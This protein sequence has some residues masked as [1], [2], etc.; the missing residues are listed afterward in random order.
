MILLFPD[1]DTLRLA[2]TS[3]LV[4][5][6]VTLAPAAVTADEQ[7]RVYVE[8]SVS[9]P[10][11]LGKTLDRLGVKGSKRH[12]LGTPRDVTSWLELL[13]LTKAAGTPAIAAQQPVLFEL[14]D[15]DDLP[16]L[17]SEMLRLG[18]D[19]QGFRW[20][21]RP[22]D[23]DRHRVLLRVIGPP[24]YTLLRALDRPAAGG[25]RAYLEAAPRVWVELGHQHPLA[26]QVK[27]AEGQTA[28]IRPPA[29]WLFLDDAP[30]RDVYELLKFDLPAG[31][32][33]WE[34]G[35][36]AD[37]IEVPLKL[38]GGNAADV[39]ELWVLREDGVGQLDALVR[40]A[41]DR[42]IERL[43]FAVADDP[44]GRRTVVLR[45][46]P[47]KLAPPELALENAVGFKPFWKLPNLFVPAGKRLHPTLR[48]ET[49]RSLLA[50][51]PEQVVWLYPDGAGGFTPEMVPDAAF[52]PLDNWVDYVI[53]AEREPLAAWI[54][55]T[56][57]DFD[58]FV[59]HEGGPKPKPPAE[60]KEPKGKETDAGPKGGKA[61]GPATKP[62]GVV[63][64]A[65]PAAFEPLP[66]EAQPVSA[67]KARRE[68]LEKEFLAAD[69]PLDAPARQAL[70]PELG[71]ANAGEGVQSEAAVCWLNAL[72]DADPSPAGWLDGWDRSERP[73]A[74]GPMTADE[75]D[76]RLTGKTGSAADARAVVAGFL[77]LA[78]QTPVP[79]WLGSRLPKVRAFVEQ[80][81]G[82][83]PVRAVWLAGYRAAQ[84][85]G[86]DVLGLARVRDRLLNRLLAEG[87]SA[88]RDLPGFLRFAGRH[89]AERLRVVRE[90]VLD[91]HGAARRWSDGVAVN[92]PYVDLLF[93]FALAKLGEATAA[94]T[95]L[96]Q[97]GKVLVTPEPADWGSHAKFD[98]TVRSLANNL[99]FRGFKY[100]VERAL[101]AE[102]TGGPLP[103]DVLAT[104]DALEARGNELAARAKAKP[105]AGGPSQTDPPPKR[106]RYVF[107]R[108][109]QDSHVLEPDEQ[110]DPYAVF[111]AEQL[112]PMHRAV[113]DLGAV[114]DP[115]ALAE[116][117]RRMYRQ[118]HPGKPV[119]EVRFE[120][121]H[122]VMM[123]S[124]RAGEAF[125][126][127]LLAAVPAV[128]KSPAAAG[129]KP[130]DSDGV[131]KKQGQLLERSLFVAA[132]FGRA[133]TVRGLV[134]EFTAL[135]RAKPEAA[136]VKLINF[137]A[138]PS[139]RS[140]RKLGMRDEIDR[141]LT[142]IQSE[143]LRGATLAELRN[144]YSTGPITWRSVLQTLLNLATGWLASGLDDHAAPILDAARAEVLR[145]LAVPPPTPP[146]P[147]K[148]VVELTR[149]YV[150][151]CG[152]ARSGAGLARIAELFEKAD[153]AAVPNS[154]TGNI[155]Y[156]RLHLMVVE[157]VVLALVNDDAGLGSAGRRWLDE[158]EYLVR[159]RVHADM[160]RLLKTS[161]L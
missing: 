58:H 16:G 18:N 32:V 60:P 21:T 42:L 71:T 30:F 27:L 9:V 57:F 51:D 33:V 154:W 113:L 79:A 144:R 49:V 99:L 86:A 112:D 145:S 31:P 74:P 43:T 28:L 84:L 122:E 102:P 147:H 127:E 100:R 4:P 123:L 160:D 59:C 37:T 14:E 115:A 72:W 140:L 118:G 88:E 128:L 17:V 46:R 41:D 134:G 103:P 116:K 12:G 161:A 148:D 40:D 54:G 47:S 10:R 120:L 95:L 26:H 151:A 92:K 29:D 109:R 85:S 93:A 15:A 94:T 22:D 11:T 156:S 142:Q 63:K 7:G 48:R 38:A 56:R 131:L 129:G 149:A 73:A 24:Y 124:P 111:T 121:L 146:A 105:Q 126:V 97:A 36:T 96:D 50:D 20:F 157:E 61:A 158:D 3:N 143:V 34:E 44:S 1:T 64:A 25:V 153:P 119:E 138:G 2:V 106:A 117:A 23:A 70:W 108:M 78:G 39:P 75:F 110:R 130:P 55:A 80:H 136:R 104:A 77:R 19:R 6:A 35:E 69:G 65:A 101:R 68:E 91:L 132:H 66:A 83:L 159:K 8:P 90:K 13:P 135:L 125:S 81:E 89:D 152:Q 107:N 52:R 133:D 76:K 139:L 45:T 53:E 114:R 155:C 67:W 98:D 141:L 5:A 150:A 82:S 62:K 137:A 87:L